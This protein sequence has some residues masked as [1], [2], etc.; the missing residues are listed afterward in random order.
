[1][2]NKQTFDDITIGMPLFEVYSNGVNSDIKS[3]KI[4]R[5]A[6]KNEDS[7]REELFVYTNYQTNHCAL[8][9]YFVPTVSTDLNTKDCH[10]NFYL[11]NDD[12]KRALSVL[13]ENELSDMKKRQQEEEEFL[14]T[15]IADCKKATKK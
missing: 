4:T 9:F 3:H 8:H 10:D 14:S 11:N 13:L 6:L 5:I 1:M 15:K 7:Q 12:A 2:K